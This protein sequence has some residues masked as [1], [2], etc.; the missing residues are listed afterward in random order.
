MEHC[1]T[2]LMI[3]YENE[4]SIYINSAK[5]WFNSVPKITSRTHLC[6]VMEMSSLTYYGSEY[7]SYTNG[8]NA[9]SISGDG[10]LI[11]GQ[12]QDEHISGGSP[13]N[14][15]QNKQGFYGEMPGLN[16]W[17]RALKKD[18]IEYLNQSRCNCVTDSLITFSKTKLALRGNV[19]ARYDVP[20]E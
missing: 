17:K 9:A 12:D 15:N 6:M 19:E 5:H 4:L 3:L 1:N 18:E 10:V 11:L 14:P 8:S 16:L 13:G 2:F 7:L 20:C